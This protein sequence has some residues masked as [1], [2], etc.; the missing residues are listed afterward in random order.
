MLVSPLRV[1]NVYEREGI[2]CEFNKQVQSS[3]PL[4]T[5]IHME[6]YWLR[7]IIKYLHV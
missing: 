4:Y 3:N 2:G 7:N 6:L 1:L 5:P